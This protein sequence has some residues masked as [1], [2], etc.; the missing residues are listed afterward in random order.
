MKYLAIST[1]VLLSSL[2]GNLSAESAPCAH[3]EV[4]R[5]YNKT[6]H[7]NFEY[8]DAYLQTLGVDRDGNETHLSDANNSK[9]VKDVK[10]SK[11]TSD[12]KP[13]QVAEK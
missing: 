4:I 8:Y 12:D 6:H 3:C 9:D 7:Q 10:D 5:E 13:S 2:T 1:I 11:K